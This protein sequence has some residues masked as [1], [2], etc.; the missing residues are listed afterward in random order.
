LNQGAFDRGLVRSCDLRGRIGDTLRVG[1]ANGFG[2]A[3]A[4]YA[5]ARHRT[6]MPADRPRNTTK[7]NNVLIGI[8]RIKQ[9]PVHL[10]SEPRKQPWIPKAV[11]PDRAHAP[12][13]PP[14]DDSPALTL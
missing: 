11:A 12:P 13:G 6:R 10:L 7:V 2:L 4:T 5:R 1:D 14:S 9:N 3:F 8:R